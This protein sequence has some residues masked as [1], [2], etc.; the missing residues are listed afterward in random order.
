MG[1]FVSLKLEGKFVMKSREEGNVRGRENIHTH[2][3][4]N[5]SRFHFGEKD[6]EEQLDEKSTGKEVSGLVGG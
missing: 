3:V 2:F 1:R 6:Q 5:V 4:A